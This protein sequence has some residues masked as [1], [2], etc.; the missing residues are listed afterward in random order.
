MKPK[1]TTTDWPLRWLVLPSWRRLHR[2]AE[3]KIV[4]GIPTGNG[5]PFNKFKRNKWKEA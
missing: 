5:V 2:V 3:T 4:A 1:V